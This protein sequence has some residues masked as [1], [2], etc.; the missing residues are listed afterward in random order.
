MNCDLENRF[1]LAYLQC[2]GWPPSPPPLS[3]GL[4]EYRGFKRTSVV[5]AW[6]SE[7]LFFNAKEA[8][9]Q[10]YHVHCIVLD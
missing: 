7:W 10:L 8:I 2:P 1:L 3:V 5:L 6:V 4:G 9:F